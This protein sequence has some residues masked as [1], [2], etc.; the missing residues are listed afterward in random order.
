MQVYRER[1]YMN[2]TAKLLYLSDAPQWRLRPLNVFGGQMSLLVC[3]V[4]G[5]AYVHIQAV[6][7]YACARQ[8]RHVRKPKD[9]RSEFATYGKVVVHAS[10][11]HQLD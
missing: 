7:Q 6:S 8:L 10:L 1:G 2:V 5:A 4:H 3:S 9:G 11:V